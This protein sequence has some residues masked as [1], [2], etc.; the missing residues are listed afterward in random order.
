MSEHNFISVSN[1]DTRLRGRPR[2]TGTHAYDPLMIFDD[3][4]RG[5]D[6]KRDC[7]SR[8]DLCGACFWGLAIGRRKLASPRLKLPKRYQLA[9]KFQ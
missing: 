1:G 5:I 9:D 2:P 3:A 7:S 8:F 6:S 4:K